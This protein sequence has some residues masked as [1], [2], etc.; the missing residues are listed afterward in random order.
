L[1]FE[2]D[3]GYY[4]DGDDHSERVEVIR[5]HELIGETPKAWHIRLK[6]GT[7]FRQEWF[8][9]SQCSLAADNKTIEVPGWLLDSKGIT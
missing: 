6:E 3:E 8:P 9:K 4:Y 5:V 1:S 2:E 7:K